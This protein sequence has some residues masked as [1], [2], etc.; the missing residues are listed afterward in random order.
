[1]AVVLLLL[2][3]SLLVHSGLADANRGCLQWTKNGE[4]VCCTSCYP[5]NHLV[6]ECGLDPKDLCK[7]CGPGLYT[8]NLKDD[9][10]T[11]C[12]QCLDPQVEV[13]KCTP[14]ADT[15]CGCKEGLLCGNDIC[16][17][18]VDKCN[19][20]QEP[21]ADRSCRPCPHGTY[22][23]QSHQKCKPWSTR[24]PYPHQVIVAKGDAFSDI[25]CENT[26]V[27]SVDLPDPRG[28]Q[29]E[30][31]HIIVLTCIA[32]LA[33]LGFIIIIMALSIQ[34]KQ[35]KSVKA[36][37]KTPIIR[38]PTDEP[39]TLIAIEC[40]FH[41]AQQEQGSSSESLIPWNEACERCLSFQGKVTRSM[42]ELQTTVGNKTGSCIHLF[43]SHKNPQVTEAFEL[44][45]S[46]TC[47][48]WPWESVATCHL[49]LSILKW[50]RRW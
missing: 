37:K 32:C 1:M 11:R 31:A 23:N 22:N 4:N 35:K 2:G 36:D 49:W 27:M 25:K 50:C 28:E 10:C 26:S 47:D 20:G 18:C 33:F 39:R 21:T 8:V 29:N 5:G 38:T 16:S 17:F 15:V 30:T 9:R 41:E 19:K 14:S 46:K 7:P 40:S 34:L 12:T 3:L 24:C 48:N 6:R 43:D 42:P 45:N 13:K 44:D